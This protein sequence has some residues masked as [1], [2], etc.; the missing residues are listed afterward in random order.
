MK[1]PGNEAPAW[2]ELIVSKKP[3]TFQYLATKILV[4][5]LVFTYQMDPSP[6]NKAKCIDELI[7]FFRK[8]IEIPTAQADL[9]TIF[10]GQLP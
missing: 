6:A 1:I 3:I 10:G 9:T 2:S 4:G 7:S 5:R 8:N